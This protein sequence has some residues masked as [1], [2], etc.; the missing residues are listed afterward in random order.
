MKNSKGIVDT[1]ENKGMGIGDGGNG[2]RTDQH[3]QKKEII[4][5]W[6]RDEKRRRLSGERNHARHYTGS[7]KTLREN[8]KGKQGCDGWTTWKN[9]SECHLKT[10]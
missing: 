9:G 6:I 1:E 3:N 2:T 4:I 5:L 7:K 8:I 10:Y